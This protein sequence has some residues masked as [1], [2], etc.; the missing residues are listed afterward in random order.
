MSFRLRVLGLLTLVAMATTA[1]TGWLTLRQA[2]RQ[3][4]ET[5]TAGRQE[6]SRITG[7]LRTYGFTHGTWD[8][9]SPTVAS[10]AQDTGQRIR[11]ATESDVLLT[12]SD[13]LAGRTPRE[14]SSQPPVLVDP[15]PVLR[16][17]AAQVRRV[18]MKQVAEAIA[19]YRTEAAYAACLTRA[20][21]DVTARPD[22]L[23]IP[24]IEADRRPAQC[25]APKDSADPL[26]PAD[27]IALQPC[28]AQQQFAACL[29]R[30]FNER[31]GPAA[32]PRL[33][34]HLGV[35]NESA[36]TLAAA[37]TVA[38]TAGVTLAVVAVALLLSRAVLRPV[39]AM[40]VA[41]KGLGE[42]DLGRR[43]PVS[44][45]D[46]I[47]QLGGAFNRMADSIQAGEERQRRLTGDI[48]HELRTPLANLRGY[49]E[50]LR[51]GVVEPTPELLDSLHREALLQQ[52][53]VDD[54]Q[55][56]ALAEAGALT[57]HPTD[58]DL[59][60]L[61]EAGRRAHLAQAEAAGVALVLEASAPV[62]VTA[63]NDRLR[64]VVGNLVGNALRATPEGGSVTLAVIPR[65]EL[66]VVEVRDTGKGIAP[67]DL[68]HLFDR[69]WRADVS[70]GR[71]TGGSGLGLSI[72]RQ[73]VT[74]H[75]GTIEVRSA[76]GA[77][78]TFTIVLPR[79]AG[80]PGVSPRPGGG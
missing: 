50:A 10:L 69:F 4:Q 28:E 47:A 41:A 62:R 68:P 57:Y 52:R 35:R 74:D 44:G 31:I 46:E 42:G 19:G 6:V 79:S 15:R 24:R 33:E 61:L 9:L 65:G 51:D 43:V 59:R 34:V 3:V 80:Q 72:A 8:G 1:A 32:P 71:A 45:R 39:R 13:A 26:T 53:I 66:A 76:V 11:V 18:S 40:T 58:V 48:A 49:L 54:L 2:N 67:E 22:K 17:P 78:T 21:A 77:G 73:I 63:D 38:V 27:L 60:D 14:P 7:E 5:V 29:R 12:D 23:G 37:P 30:V 55:D 64:Q 36:P 16:V 25:P 20:G 70:R 75:R 56:L